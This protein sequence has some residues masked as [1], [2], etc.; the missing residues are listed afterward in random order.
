MINQFFHTIRQNLRGWL[1]YAGALFIIQVALAGVFNQAGAG[2]PG[3]MGM[4]IDLLPD[5]V[6][7][8]VGSSELDL[9]TANGMLAV[10]YNH[11]LTKVALSVF[12]VGLT[13]GA[14][15][16][17]LERGTLDLIL[18]RPVRRYE[19]LLGSG[20]ATVLAALLVGGITFL[21]TVIGAN[22]GGVS[23]D[24]TWN[25]FVW[26]AFSTTAL[27]L[28][29]S[30]FGY[31]FSTLARRGGQAAG[32]TGGLIAGMFFLDWFGSLWDKVEPL[33]ALS[34][35]HYH[36]PT[37]IIMN[38]ANG[39]INTTV[40]LIVAVLTFAAAIVIFERRDLIR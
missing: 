33:T 12:A 8:F 31:L 4:L 13:A 34:L 1:I 5:T 2:L 37:A 17:E 14:I 7:G 11:P 15:A 16:G 29:M 3:G 9:L 32:W 40:L 30:G 6:R 38:Q 18:A 20:L 36:T 23:G 35:F 26:L 39:W 22:I 28:A 21:G 27:V 19:L 25:Y 24:V 10:A